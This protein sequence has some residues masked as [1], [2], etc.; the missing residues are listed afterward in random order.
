MQTMDRKF[1]IM[2]LLIAL[3]IGYVIYAGMQSSA[4]YY[5][6]VDEFLKQQATPGSDG[7]RI[8][9]IVASG[10]IQRQPAANEIRFT[11]Q[12]TAV[13]TVLAVNYK[14]LIPNM[15]KDG[16]SVVIEGKYQPAAKVFQAVNLMT[17]CPSKYEAKISTPVPKK[18]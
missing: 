12:G 16:S 8:A 4:V 10:S 7:V 13:N 11:L 5:L 14:G 2:G 1:V 3:G 18:P 15:F 6:T 17:S 9:G